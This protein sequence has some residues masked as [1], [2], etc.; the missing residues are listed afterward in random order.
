MDV[1]YDTFDIPTP[2]AAPK[3][4]CSK[5][6]WKATDLIVINPKHKVLRPKTN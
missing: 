6:K 3:M 4:G 1:I 2:L 5:I